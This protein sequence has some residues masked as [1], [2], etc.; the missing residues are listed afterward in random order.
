MNFYERQTLNMQHLY[1]LVFFS[2]KPLKP[3]LCYQSI[4]QLFKLCVAYVLDEHPSGC[5]LARIGEYVL[6]KHDYAKKQ[7]FTMFV[8]MPCASM[9]LAFLF[10]QTVETFIN[11]LRLGPLGLE[12]VLIFVVMKRHIRS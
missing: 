12:C 7:L 3:F 10:L 2:L 8:G 6:L 1:Y 9:R 11:I 5:L 4:G